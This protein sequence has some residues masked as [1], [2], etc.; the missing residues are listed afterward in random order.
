VEVAGGTWNV[1]GG[2][3]TGTTP[4]GWPKL[5]KNTPSFHDGIFMSDMYVPSSNAPG[6]AVM[7]FN[8]IDFQNIL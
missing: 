5:V 3:M 2:Y 7:I 4:S 6:D 8:F 1:A